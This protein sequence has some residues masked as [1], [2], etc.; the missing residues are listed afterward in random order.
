ML[1]EY[2]GAA[3]RILSPPGTPPVAPPGPELVQPGSPFQCGDAMAALPGRRQHA[4]RTTLSA[5]D[6]YARAGLRTSLERLHTL[7]PDA[8][9]R[10]LLGTLDV[11]SHRLDAWITS[12]ATKRLTAMRQA[13]ATGVYLGAYGWVENLR[14]AAPGT[15]LPAPP[16]ESAPVTRMPGNPGFT[17][18]PSLTQAA[19]VAVLRNGHLTHAHNDKRDLLAID[20]SSERARL[21]DTLLS[22][23]RA[24]QPLGAL[25]GYRFERGLHENHPGL[26]LDTFIDRCRTL[27]P[28]TA[29]RIDAAGTVVDNV[30]I[31]PVVDGL[32]L[33]RQWQNEGEAVSSANWV[34][35]MLTN[36]S[37]LA[38]CGLKS[39]PW[40]TP[41]T[42]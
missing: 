34:C 20:L 24:G 14:P 3:T 17:H 26:L 33:F 41:L 35:G 27:A 15:L 1:L 13:H 32:A 28:L 31:G 18:A 2:A 36:P 29:T 10:L 37:R 25:L 5:V 4:Q 7:A 11:C 30:A 42:R 6:E 19:T 8:L 39:S 21:A 23:V 40:A 38:P 22:G 9:S 16:G 12:L